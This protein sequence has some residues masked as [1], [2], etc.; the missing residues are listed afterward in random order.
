MLLLS[1]V[2]LYIKKAWVVIRVIDKG[3][4]KK[5]IQI[6]KAFTPLSLNQFAENYSECMLLCHSCWTEGSVVPSND[7]LLIVLTLCSIRKQ[8]KI[9]LYKIR[10]S[11]FYYE[12]E[13]SYLQLNGTEKNPS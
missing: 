11:E 2:L 3:V 10:S 12:E 9:I 1:E 5:Q 4:K 6:S 7:F 8:L 13:R